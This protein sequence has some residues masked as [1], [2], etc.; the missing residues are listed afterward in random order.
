M[1]HTHLLLFLSALCLLWTAELSAQIELS[2][3]F[4]DNMVLQQ[5]ANVPVWGKAKAGKTVRITTSWD[6]KTYSQTADPTGFWKVEIQTPVAGGPYTITL[7]SG[8]TIKLNNVMAGDVW[9]CSGQSNMEMQVLGWGKVNNYEEE[10]K[11]AA[12]PDIR[13]LQIEKEV[14]PTPLNDIKAAG[15]GWQVCSPATVP[16][17]SAVGYFFGRSIHQSQHIP[18]GLINTSWGGTIAETWTSRES[19]EAMK[20][21]TEAIKAVAAMTPGQDKNPNRP[22][23]LYNA[24]LHPLIPYT[25]KGA[26][27][28]QGEANAGRA[29]Q[30]RELFPLMITDWR[31]QWGYDFPFYFVQLANYMKPVAEPAESA[32]AELREAQQKT[33][34]LS[35][36][37]MAVTIDIG[38]ADDIHPKNKQ[39]VGR[40]LA[41][42][43]RA[44]TYGEKIDYSGP[45][46]ESYTIEGNR[47]R[48]FFKHTNGGLQAKGGEPLKG[49][50][51]AG[52]DHTFHWADA[53]IDGNTVVVSSPEVSF[54]VAV[55]YA[56]ADN[57]A[58]NLSNGTQL[59][60][61]PFRTDDWQGVT[62][63]KK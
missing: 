55:R 36:T 31:K 18:I 50:A 39:D 43:A 34:H 12:Y 33:L 32:W 42:A 49:F 8:K 45:A 14:S 16:D 23:L 56:W 30:Y 35:N 25:I 13:F 5:Q 41:L 2:P 20:E 48:L 37:G 52:V 3:V 38:D 1:K 11:D 57:P 59:P 61:S 15:N 9:I 46:Y 63:G 10:I 24:M 4:S 44:N 51:I 17:F 40:R 29:Y 47:I 53:V 62:Y 7:S 26:I 27:W 22:T 60:A 21:F 28:Y 54:P 58:C 19:L 6:N